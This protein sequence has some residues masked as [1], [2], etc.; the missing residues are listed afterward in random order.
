M[1]TFTD[2]G[3]SFLDGNISSLL[4]GSVSVVDLKMIYQ[5]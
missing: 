3:I 5:Y 4:L 2:K 1:Q